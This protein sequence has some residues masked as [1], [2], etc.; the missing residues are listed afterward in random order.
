[1]KSVPVIASLVEAKNEEGLK[2]LSQQMIQNAWYKIRFHPNDIGQ[3]IHGACPS[4]MLHA[5]L[6]GIFK[7]TRDCFFEQIGPTSQL[8]NDINGLAQQ[9]GEAF[10][11]QSERDVPNCVFSEGIVRG[12]LMAN[13]FRGILLVIAAIFQSEAGKLRLKKNKNFSKSSQ[14][15]NWGLLVEML[16][17]W[18]AFLNE[19]K[20]TYA[21]ITRLRKKHR[22]I[23]YLVR[24]LVGKSLKESL[25]SGDS[26]RFRLAR[27]N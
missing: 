9:Y 5:L 2:Q 20:M 22:Y 14:I 7:Y 1:M 25:N 24:S 8:A 11:R 10:G 12:K 13:E 17:E 4:E 19:S 3:G 16:L 21:H 23:M 18:E 27:R 15:A 26:F 6:L